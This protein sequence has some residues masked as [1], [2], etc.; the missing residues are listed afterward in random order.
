[1]H[2]KTDKTRSKSKGAIAQLVEQRTENPCVPG[3][4]PGGTTQNKDDSLAQLVEHN[5]FNVGVL[6]SSPRRITEGFINPTKT[7]ENHRF[8]E[9]LLYTLCP[10]SQQNIEI[11]SVQKGGK[12]NCTTFSHL[13]R[14]YFIIFQRPAHNKVAKKLATSKAL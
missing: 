13:Q 14:I 11:S 7:S 12:K 10:Q 8:S 9:V 3:S 4:I 1:M 6:G 5:T 2:R